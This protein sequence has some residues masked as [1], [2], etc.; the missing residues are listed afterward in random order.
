MYTFRVYREDGTVFV[1]IVADRD[2][3]IELLSA[4]L[5]Y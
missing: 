5:L 3:V 4:E 1:W 2:H